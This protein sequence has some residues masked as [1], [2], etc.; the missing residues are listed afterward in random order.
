M[1]KILLIAASLSFFSASVLAAP[2][3][4]TG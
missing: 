2:D 4:V 1:K 3:C